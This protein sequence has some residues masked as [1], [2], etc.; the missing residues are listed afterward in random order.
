M[1]CGSTDLLPTRFAG[2][3]VAIASIF[4]LGTPFKE[5]ED[6]LIGLAPHCARE[7]AVTARLCCGRCVPWRG[8]SGRSRFCPR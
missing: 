3:L 4:E 8:V 1:N 7:A 2:V 5:L 6:Q